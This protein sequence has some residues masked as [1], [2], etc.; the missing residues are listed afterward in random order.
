MNSLLKRLIWNRHT[1]QTV[2]DALRF[3]PVRRGR[4]MCVCWGGKNYNCNPRAITDYLVAKNLAT[5]PGDRPSQGKFEVYYAFVD[6]ARFSKDFSES[7]GAVEICTLRYFYLLATSQFIIANTRFGGQGQWPFPKKKGQYYIQTMHGGH[8]IKKVELDAREVLWEEYIVNLYNDAERIDLMLSDSSYWTQRLRTAFAYPQ[9]EIMEV[10]LPRNDIFFQ[11]EDIK[12]KCRE[13]VV[14]LVQQRKSCFLSNISKFLIY[15]PTFRADGSIDVYGF[16]FEKVLLAL[17]TRFGGEWYILVS[18]H[19]NM[20]EYYH[21]IYDFSHPRLVDFGREDLQSLLVACDAM[22]TDYSSCE[23]DFSLSGH[24]VF[25]L[26]KDLERYDRGFYIDPRTLP[27]PYADNDDQLVNNILSFDQ[28]KYSQDLTRFNQEV[29][30]LKETGQA[31][32][33]VVEWM[34]L[35]Y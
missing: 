32:D 23:M 9:G 26:C 28:E 30:G 7:L 12:D 25:Q 8:G 20:Q 31:C 6:V 19:P 5:K 4:V 34:S 11:G 24:P 29:I 14:S 10:G 27:F 15:A 1:R 16:D 33:A 3:L 35:H 2:L 18:S 21:G 13:R 17:T 22:I